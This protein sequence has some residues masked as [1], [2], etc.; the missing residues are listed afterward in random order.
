[1]LV[2]KNT[3]QKCFKNYSEYQCLLKYLLTVWTKIRTDKNAH[4][5]S[6]LK[7]IVMKIF[8]NSLDPDQDRLNVGPDLGPNC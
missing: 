8:A 2:Y 4:V 6:V 7:I 5:R 1:M 3:C